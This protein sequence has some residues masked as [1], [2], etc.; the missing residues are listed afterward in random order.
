LY[1][2]DAQ[3]LDVTIGHTDRIRDPAGWQAQAQLA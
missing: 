3:L 2:L 1:E